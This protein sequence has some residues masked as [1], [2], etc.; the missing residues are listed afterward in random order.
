[1]HC[2]AVSPQAHVCHPSL[3]ESTLT[4]ADATQEWLSQ[5]EAVKNEPLEIVY[6]YWDG[7][8]HRRKVR[9]C[10]KMPCSLPAMGMVGVIRRCAMT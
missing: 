10:T 3:A 8:G 1:M 7:S 2:L 5:Q 4:D 6:S 9:V